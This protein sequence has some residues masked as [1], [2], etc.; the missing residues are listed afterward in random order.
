MP[1]IVKINI[2]NKKNNLRWVPLSEG[3]V[4]SQFI[5]KKFKT[6]I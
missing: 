4:F 6:L 1:E 3:I 5:K 2:N